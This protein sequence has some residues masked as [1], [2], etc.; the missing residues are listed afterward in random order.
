[1]GSIVSRNTSIADSKATSVGS[2]SSAN[3]SAGQRLVV[4][5]AEG[6]IATNRSLFTTR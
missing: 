4:H 3:I 2:A 6:A 5:L 1:M